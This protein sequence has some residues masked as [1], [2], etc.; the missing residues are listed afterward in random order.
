MELS[1]RHIENLYQFTRDHF[2]EYYDLQTELV[3][4]LANDIEAIWEQEPNLSFVNARE[5]AFKKFGV[6]GFSDVVIHRE[7]AMT[8]RYFKYLWRELKIWFSLPKII[9]TLALSICFYTLLVSQFSEYYIYIFYG[10][11]AVRCTYKSFML[12][13]NFKKK[14]KASKQK[15]LL[16][17]LIFK[18][19]GGFGMVLIYYNINLLNSTTPLH[20][21]KYL[22]IVIS[23]LLSVTCLLAYIS[24]ELIPKK[25]EELL[26]ETYPEYHLQTT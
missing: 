13:R 5:K 19:A 6:Y 23:V 20:Q 3:D 2:V 25:S 11:L 17:D 24:L 21:T 9:I 12:N 15:W 22:V 4:H 18:Q 14:S 26:E 7:R 8:K 10:I 1:E 16:E